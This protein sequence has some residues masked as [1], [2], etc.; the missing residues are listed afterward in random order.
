MAYATMS[1]HR[2]MDLQWLGMPEK[3]KGAPK[4]KRS[5]YKIDDEKA[6]LPFDDRRRNATI[7]MNQRC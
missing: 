5:T 6:A 4:D 7:S 3:D 2:L 1:K